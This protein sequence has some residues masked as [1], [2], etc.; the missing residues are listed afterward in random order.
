MVS[1]GPED[2]RIRLIKAGLE[3]GTIRSVET[4]GKVI[5]GRDPEGN[6]FQLEAARK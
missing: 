6:A 4:G 3:I 1:V 5:D 2:L